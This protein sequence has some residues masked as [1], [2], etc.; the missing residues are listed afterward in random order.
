MKTTMSTGML[1]ALALAGSIRVYGAAQTAQ[2][3]APAKTSAKTVAPVRYFPNV[4]RRAQMYYQG[5]WGI[6]DLRVKYTEQGEIIRFSY[7]VVDPAKAAPLHDKKLVPVLIDS[8]TGVKLVVPQLE[9]V[10]QLRQSSTPIAGNTYWMGFSN[11]GRRI[12][13]GD[14][15]MVE[16]GN[17]HAMNLVVE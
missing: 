6:D 7:R 11:M 4:P 9:K 17:F 5:A 3:P 12:R 2:S 8:Q 16:I 1:L 15:V 13:P 14:R 10:G